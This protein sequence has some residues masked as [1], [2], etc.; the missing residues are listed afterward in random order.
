MSAVSN[1]MHKI[2]LIFR[3]KKSESHNVAHYQR[4]LE[5]HL[6]QHN[7]AVRTAAGTAQ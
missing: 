4:Q 6:A 1:R 2:D 5:Q 3:L 7:E